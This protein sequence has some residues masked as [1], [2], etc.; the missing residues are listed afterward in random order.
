MKLIYTILLLLISPHLFSQDLDTLKAD[1]GQ[2]VVT[3]YEGNRSLM[4]TP[5]AIANIE[6]ASITGLNEE[7][8]LYGL[9][10]VPGVRIEQRAPGSYRVAI[11]GSSLRAPFG[12]RNVKIYW[13]DIPFT[14]PS[15]STPLN[16]LDVIN[17]QEVEVIKGPAGSIYGAGNGGVLLLN[18]RQ[19]NQNEVGSGIYFGSYGL[20]RY[21]ANIEQQVERGNFRFNY[22]NQHLDG[23]REQSFFKRQTAELSSRFQLNDKQVIKT[24]F[25]YSDLY[26]GIPGG[27]T[28]EQYQNEPSQAR[29][30]NP[31]VLGSVEANASIDQQAF[32]A[33]ISHDVEV[34]EN[35]S[36]LTTLYGTFSAFEN[37]FNLDY[38]KDSRKSGGGRTRFYYDTD[39]G[40]VRTRFTFG[41]EYQTAN[42]AARNFENDNG[43]TDALNFDDEI[44]IRT[45]IVFL[46]TEFDLPGDIYV[47]GG[48]S[49]NRLEYSL[50][51]LVTNL[52]DDEAGLAEKTFNPE[53]IPRVGLV[54]KF[55]PALS[56]HTSISYGFS[57]PTIE[58]FRT[59]EGS[60]ALD[61]EAEQ[62]TNYE[63]GARGSFQELRFSYDLTTFYFKLDETIV[64]QPSDRN[65]TVVFE[66]TGAT[67]QYGIELATNWRLMQNQTRFVQNLD[68]QFSYTYH[69][70]EFVDYQK[71]GNDYSGNEL[72]GVAP[73]TVVT[74]LRA[75]TEPGLYVNLSYNFTD[76][77][78]LNDA[79]TVY[80]NSY[81]LV[82]SRIGLK[83]ELFENVNLDAFFGV[84]NLLDEKYSLGN[85]LNAFGDRFYQPAA[86]RNWFGGIK[87]NVE[88]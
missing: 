15:G 32:L 53:I 44:K 55:T 46:K 42:Y 57:P 67:D 8:I 76:E 1:L 82:Q 22:S 80:S 24:S 5:G 61:L 87:L 34:N 56:L 81:H 43:E 75:E 78:P 73:H 3:G 38:K 64:Q 23:Y 6:A 31:F 16:L 26:Y 70:F 20:Q 12:V 86:P 36:N 48:L 17:M 59:N 28:L 58:E 21:T 60:I 47:T 51:R 88:L 79:N 7:S 11:R 69:D 33:G 13:N 2:I 65:S 62:G 19:S 71:E 77:I 83:K 9:N 45:S 41:G 49:Y 72:T 74:S 40:E 14:E 25:L 68:W 39:I 66:N 10:K 4:E 52:E 30:G 63:V 50:N 29:P 37:P 27:L 84:D 85:D 18:S 35:L 54:K